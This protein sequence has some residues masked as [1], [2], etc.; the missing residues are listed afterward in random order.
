MTTTSCSNLLAL[1]ALKSVSP[2]CLQRAVHALTE[3]SLAITFTVN[4]RVRFGTGKNVW[5]RDGCTI[6]RHGLN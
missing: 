5:G 6:A 1:T 2:D 4:P 3:N